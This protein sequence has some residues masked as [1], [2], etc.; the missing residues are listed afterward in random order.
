[1][2]TASLCLKNQCSRMGQAGEDCRSNSSFGL[3]FVI[4]R[5]MNMQLLTFDDSYIINSRQI[6]RDSRHL[7]NILTSHDINYIDKTVHL[8]SKLKILIITIPITIAP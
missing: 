6:D 3:Y 1:M 2:F 4:N 8:L 7:L 5:Q